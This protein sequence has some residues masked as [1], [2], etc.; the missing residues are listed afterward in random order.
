MTEQEL[1][2]ERYKHLFLN[3]KLS[4]K[5]QSIG[6]DEP[7]F[8]RWFKHNFQLNVLGSPYKHNSGEVHKNY[9][10]APTFDQVRVW[11]EE[12][13]HLFICVE[14]GGEK[15]GVYKHDFVV[16]GNGSTS[17]RGFLTTHEAW[18]KAIEAAIKLIKDK[19]TQIK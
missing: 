15:H 5:L 4:I 13:H 7:V 3:E 14:S 10:G 8:A 6:F 2:Y 16:W 19:E 18:Y 11:F 1:F 17:I 12:K 9:I